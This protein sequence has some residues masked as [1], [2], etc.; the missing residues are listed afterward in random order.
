MKI[1]ESHEELSKLV[2]IVSDRES[3]W[4]VM[5]VD[6]EKHPLNTHISFISI[7]VQGE[8]HVV[9][10]DHVDLICFDTDELSDLFATDSPKYI[11]Q[12]KK[13]LH[14]LNLSGKLYDVDS[15]YYLDSMETIDYN[16]HFEH[17]TNRL[18]MMGVYDDH[19]KSIPIMK[20][21]ESVQ[22][23]F[24]KYSGVNPQLE[25]YL[26]FNEK[27]IPTLTK[28]ESRGL[29]VDKSKLV[30]KYSE[31]QL[32]HVDENQ[33]VYTEYNP[34]TATGRPSN[35]HGGVNYA[36]LNKKDGTR[37][38]F[39][40]GDS[41]FVHFDFDGYHPR[42]IG[43]L[44][45]FELPRT[46]AHEYLADIYGVG[47]DESKGITFKNLYG[48]IMDEYKDHPFFKQTDEFINKHWEQVT[49]DGYIKTL[50]REILLSWVSDINPQKAFNYLLQAIE[51]EKNIDK[52][53]KIFDIIDE[54]D[55][56]LI[57]YTY[58]SFLFEVPKNV[59]KLKLREIYNILTS[60][61]YPITYSYGT[62]YQEL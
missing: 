12:K 13:V 40:S 6:S 25:G 10:L 62:T 23:L 21:S 11:F 16:S 2:D 30:D 57:L 61:G 37:E 31:K 46:S 55:I 47:Y 26:W 7:Q 35:R 33:R 14:S 8:V 32:K 18:Y 50:Y 48:G 29:L 44:I 60:G 43:E 39:Y 38:I 59:D 45:D 56:Y 5:W 24:N 17:L 42:I 15:Y 19:I 9:G 22:E 27:Y 51:T 53:D 28:L 52:L 34:F 1:V 20:L 58:D 54:T 4:F 41:V 3:H 49:E 36:G